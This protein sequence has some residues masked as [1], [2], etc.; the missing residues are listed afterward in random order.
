[1]SAKISTLLRDENLRKKMGS[2]ARELVIENYTIGEMS[3]K[4]LKIYNELNTRE[5]KSNGSS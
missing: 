1:M 5:T 4:I 2:K 3:R